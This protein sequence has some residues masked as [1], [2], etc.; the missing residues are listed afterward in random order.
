MSF[1][2]S[3][4]KRKDWRKAYK[5]RS[6]KAVDGSCRNHGSCPWCQNGRQHTHKKRMPAIDKG[7]EE[8]Q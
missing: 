2:K 4:P 3:Y 6:A 7:D 1:D 5:S 8:L